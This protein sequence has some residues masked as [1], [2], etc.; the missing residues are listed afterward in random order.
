MK[1]YPLHLIVLAATLFAAS[2]PAGLAQ[3]PAVASVSKTSFAEDT[4][5]L[6][7]GGDFYLYLGTVPRLEK[8]S[9]N[10]EGGHK[11]FTLFPDAQADEFANINKVSD[12]VAHLITDRVSLQTGRTIVSGRPAVI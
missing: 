8:L 11:T 4:A 7:P 10:V 6:D 3:P 12:L 9:A 2:T 1:N 5:Q